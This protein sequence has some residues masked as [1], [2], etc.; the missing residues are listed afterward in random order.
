MKRF[1]KILLRIFIAHISDWKLPEIVLVFDN[2]QIQFGKD[3]KGQLLVVAGAKPKPIFIGSQYIHGIV[4]KA[5]LVA[6]V[7]DA[8]IHFSIVEAVEHDCT[9]GAFA[10]DI[11]VFGAEF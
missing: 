6:C 7:A 2:I 5:I 1:Q 4:Q 8:V 9:L 10:E 11:P 3:F